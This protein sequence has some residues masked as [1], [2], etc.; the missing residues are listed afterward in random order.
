MQFQITARRD[1]KVFLFGVEATTLQDAA[2][3]AQLV[4]GW[5]WNVKAT[6]IPPPCYRKG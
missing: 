4:V 5:G 6:L 1:A 3:K 2:I